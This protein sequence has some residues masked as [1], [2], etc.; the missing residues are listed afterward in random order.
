LLRQSGWGQ[1]SIDENGALAGLDSGDI[2]SIN[3]LWTTGEWDVWIDDI[4]LYR[5]KKP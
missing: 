1:K 2:R 4:A 5:R 3:F